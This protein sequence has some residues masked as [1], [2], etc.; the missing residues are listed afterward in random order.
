MPENKPIT[1]F[2]QTHLTPNL[3]RAKCLHAFIVA[4]IQTKTV[5]LVTLSNAFMGNALCESNYKRLKRFLSE[6]AFDPR[7]F[8]QTI[9][10]IIGLDFTE[11][12][13]LVLDRTNWKF[14]KLHIN[15]LYL[16]VCY[17]S[18]AI[19]LFCILLEDKKK[20][21]QISWIVQTL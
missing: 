12:W 3:A 15:I 1:T 4:L 20:V 10:Y 21:I 19:P 6:I 8:A 18:V 5:N 16:A 2:L 11:K 14:G 17:K 9:A 7:P 13:L